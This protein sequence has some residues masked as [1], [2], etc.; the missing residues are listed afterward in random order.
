MKKIRCGILKISLLIALVAGMVCS[1]SL[2]LKAADFGVSASDNGDGT[3]SVNIS[4]NVAGRF[5]VSANGQ[6]ATIF[7]NNIG[8]GG[9]ATIATGNGNF[10][11]TAAPTNA[12]DANYNLLDGVVT[13]SVQVGQTQQ[14]ETP[15]VPTPE[16]PEKTTET[17]KENPKEATNEKNKEETKEKKDL[18]SDNKLAS[19]TVSEG[20]LSPSFTAGNTSYRLNLTGNV[21]SIDISAKANDSKAVIE[22]TGK[23]SLK[24][25][26]NKVIITVIAEDGSIKNYT[27]NISVDKKPE[28]YLNYNGSKLGVMVD[29]DGVDGLS[30]KFEKV[31][32]KIDG[33]EIQAWKNELLNKT[34]VYMIDEKSGEKNFY[35]YNESSKKI[36]SVFKPMSILGNNFYIVDID[37]SLQKRSGME[38]G[39]VKIDKYDLAGW[40][41]TDK[42]FANYAL[43]YVMDEKGQM[44]YYQYEA[45]EKILQIYSGAATITQQ[46]Y[47]DYVKSVAA[48]L[49][50]HKYVIYGLA[51]FSVILLI[52]IGFLVFFRK[53]KT[54]KFK[55]VDIQG[56][57]HESR[58]HIEADALTNT[59]D[60][61]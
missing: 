48:S 14:P 19:L 23:I 55:K 16:T 27:L 47:D 57:S 30:S 26:N 42:E 5:D 46:G 50:K 40:K 22:G 25:G 43:I 59:D 21:T 7:I 6:T 35:I 9:S 4:G 60:E 2:L 28:V 45:S 34:I 53:K 41:F 10:T 38:F 36:E 44:K 49:K 54:T 1:N 52:V 33:K 31:K 37:K 17:P 61:E 58:F 11:V 3:I 51:G 12:T 20:T 56:K 29:L 39:T 24:T 18:S 8:D 13:T 32:I 15:S